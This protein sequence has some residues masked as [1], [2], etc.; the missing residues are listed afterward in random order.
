MKKTIYNLSYANFI[1]DYLKVER[2]AYFTDEYGKFMDGS[3][4]KHG[5]VAGLMLEGGGFLMVHL[6]LLNYSKP[7]FILKSYVVI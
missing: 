2:A 1:G 4:V 7:R 6:I 5:C 3:D